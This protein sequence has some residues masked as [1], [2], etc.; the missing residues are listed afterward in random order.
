MIDGRST[1]LS[2]LTPWELYLTTYHTLAR[3]TKQVQDLLS[4]RNRSAFFII[5]EAHYMKQDAGVWAGAVCES[6][7]PRVQTMRFDGNTVSPELR[8]RD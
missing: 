2:F 5:D 1:I 6:E 4:E 7:W 3:D 8:G